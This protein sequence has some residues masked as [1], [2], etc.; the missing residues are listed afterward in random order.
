MAVNMQIIYFPKRKN[1][2]LAHF[3][4]S[5]LNLHRMIL[6]LCPSR[7][8]AH[9]NKNKRFLEIFSKIAIFGRNFDY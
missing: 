9:A 4:A 7:T 1:Y 3:V 8:Q 5:Y 6:G 2:K